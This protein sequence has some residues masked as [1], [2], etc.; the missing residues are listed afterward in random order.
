MFQKSTLQA[1]LVVIVVTS[2][3]GITNILI[4]DDVA[5]SKRE[6]LTETVTITS[7]LNV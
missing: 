1:L 3:L 7:R 4:A 5:D 6:Q 2:A